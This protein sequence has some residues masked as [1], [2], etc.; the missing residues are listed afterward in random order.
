MEDGSRG[1]S[2]RFGKGI[3]ADSNADRAAGSA[4]RVAAGCPDDDVEAAL[5]LEAAMDAEE[6]DSENESFDL[7]RAVNVAVDNLITN[8]GGDSG[9]DDMVDACFGGADFADHDRRGHA[10]S[11]ARHS[12]ADVVTSANGEEC[13]DDD[14]D[15]VDDGNDAQEMNDIDDQW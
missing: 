10:T 1:D 11:F 2:F 12:D 7:S 5:A 4:C 15:D 8:D 6:A 9:D 14:D 3:F 13:V